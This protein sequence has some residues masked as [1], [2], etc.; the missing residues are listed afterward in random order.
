MQVRVLVALEAEI[1]SRLGESFD[2]QVSRGSREHSAV[3]DRELAASA[4]GTKS[5]G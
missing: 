4:A 3:L 1:R 2:T 5:T